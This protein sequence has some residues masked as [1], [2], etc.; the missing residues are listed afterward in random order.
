MPAAHCH[1]T[2]HF[3]CSAQHVTLRF[4][5]RENRGWTAYPLITDRKVILEEVLSVAGVVTARA[6]VVAVRMPE[7]MV[8]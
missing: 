3:P 7:A 2:T 6:R 4:G 1:R 5:G 8:R